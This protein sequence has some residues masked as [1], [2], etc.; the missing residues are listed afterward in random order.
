MARNVEHFSSCV[1]LVIHTSSLKALF[2]LS[3]HFFIG[4]LILWEFS[5]LS[6][7]CILVIISLSAEKLAKIFSS[8]WAVS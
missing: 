2:S 5:F 4:S 1:F 3:A 6:F 7:L 8:L